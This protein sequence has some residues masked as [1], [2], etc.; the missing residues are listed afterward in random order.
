MALRTTLILLALAAVG[1][2]GC[3]SAGTK[4]GAGTSAVL[5]LKM[6]ASDGNDADAAYF[7]DQVRRRTAGRVRIEIDA[8]SYSSVDPDNEL[9]L[10]R[11]L[12]AGSVA[13]A[14]VPSRAWERAGLP[15]FRA[16][17][18]P[19]LIDDYRLLKDVATGDVG[20][21]MLASL[22][23]AGLVG[24]GLVPMELR[25]LLGK[26]SLASPRALA[27]ARIR[28]VTS[29]T[30]VHDL[31]SLGATPVTDLDAH[32]VSD[33]LARGDLDGVETDVHASLGNAYTSVAPYM[34]SNLPLFAKA[35]TIVI[36]RD[37][38]ARLGDADQRA[39]R[40]AAKATVEH[41]DPQAQETAEVKRLCAAGLRLVPATQADV[42]AFRARAEPVVAQLARDPVT[43]SEIMTITA[44]RG[45]ASASDTL[46]TCAPDQQGQTSAQQTA[47]FPQGR[48]ASHLTKADFDAA[49]V[50]PDPQ[51]PPDP[52]VITMRNGRWRT[53]EAPPFG[54]TY[55]V[56]GDELTF[57]IQEPPENKGTRETVKWS[58]YRGALT[59]HSV[60]VADAGSR[61]IYDTHPWRRIGR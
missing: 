26:R 61:V 42:D 33:A 58:Y 5:A 46:P 57:L 56:D 21:Q 27:G 32:Q 17:Q 30:S 36:R 24:L 25:R 2:A 1:V 31:E 6:Q 28:V 8:R 12:R 50:V 48:Y 22:D 44:L 20:A 34:T 49:G 10:V 45:D 37:V 18:A 9:R 40:E 19:F 35:Q 14:Y 52:W 55:S 43:A 41:A 51:L 47:K 16:L 4:A 54:G 13:I 60:F 38:L 3:G 53:N 23:K 29:P 15:G 39:M 7:A 59:L 11:D